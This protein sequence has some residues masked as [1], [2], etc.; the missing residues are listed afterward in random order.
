MLS[1]I[2]EIFLTRL[3]SIRA[4]FASGVLVKVV[5]VAVYLV[6]FVLYCSLHQNICQVY[7]L[8]DTICIQILIHGKSGKSLDE[9]STTRGVNENG[10]HRQRLPKMGYLNIVGF[11]SHMLHSRE[12]I[13]M[14][15]RR[16]PRGKTGG[17]VY[18]TQRE[19]VHCSWPRPH[20]T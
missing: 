10:L 9:V 19:S 12:S 18:W 16:Y 4:V 20:V 8:P 5:I 7:S 6:R 1:S 11:V 14:I 17:P 15:R 13:L 3:T 2:F